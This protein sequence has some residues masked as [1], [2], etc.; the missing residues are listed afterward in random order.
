MGCESVGCESVSYEAVL[1]ANKFPEV[2]GY[3]GWPFR[4]GMLLCGWRVAFMRHSAMWAG[5]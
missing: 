4:S 5:K 3:E 1:E 2:F